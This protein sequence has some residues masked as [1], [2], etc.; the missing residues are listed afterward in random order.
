MQIQVFKIPQKSPDDLSGLEVLVVQGQLDPSHIVAVMGKTEGNGCVNDFTRGFATQTLKAYLRD[1]AGKL[2]ADRTIYVM[3]GGTEGV[4]SPHLTVFTRQPAA[5]NQP[6]HWGLALGVSRTRPFL[7]A[8][9]GTMAMVQTV[10]EAVRAAIVEA[11]LAPTHVH[12]VQIKCPLVTSSQQQ[13]ASRASTSY[14]SMAYSRG[15]SALGVAMA[16]GEIDPTQLTDAAIC[17]DYSLY[18]SIASTSAGVELQHCEV[19]VLGN[20]PTVTSPFV[21][22]HSVMQHGLDAQAVLQAIASTQQPISQV[23]NIFAKA[24]AD[25][26]GLILGCRHTMLDDSDINHTRMA[27][28]VVGAVI[29]TTVQD[30]M[31]YVSGGAEHQGPAGGGTLAAI[32]RLPDRPIN[33]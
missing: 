13:A 20:A 23:V 28:A 7:P 17:S 5:P 21:I 10:A 15:A 30:P 25:P 22:G 26:S 6:K 32:A 19:L 31:V 29:A 18:S 24:E 4:L 11:Q 1:R 14:Q 16:L 3:S 33:F 9:I 2:I 8:E 12:F 27:R